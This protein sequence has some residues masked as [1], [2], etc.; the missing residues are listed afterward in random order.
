MTHTINRLLFQMD[1]F[2]MLC[3]KFD[4]APSS[5]GLMATGEYVGLKTKEHNINV[6]RTAAM[7]L[8]NYACVYLID[9]YE[10]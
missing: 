1:I 8:Q 4:F 3:K 10:R 7:Y 6:L 9:K 5:T 2:M